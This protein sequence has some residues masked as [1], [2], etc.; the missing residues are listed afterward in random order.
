[1]FSVEIKVPI[2]TPR[3]P[4]H[5]MRVGS[6]GSA[7]GVSAVAGGSGPLMDGRSNG[8]RPVRSPTCRAAEGR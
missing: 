3:S 8:Y 1:M 4:S 5:G 7:A 2:S 6:G